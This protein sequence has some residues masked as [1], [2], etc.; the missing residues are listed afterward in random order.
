MI[1]ASGNLTTCFLVHQGFIVHN[2]FTAFGNRTSVFYF[3]VDAHR[4]I[5][6][7]Y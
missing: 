5:I 3:V 1:D 4:K 7:M 2:V 6:M